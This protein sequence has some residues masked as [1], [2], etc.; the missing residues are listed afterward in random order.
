[1][2]Q[3]ADRATFLGAH[4]LDTVLGVGAVV[5]GKVD[6]PPRQHRIRQN[7]LHRFIEAVVNEPGPQVGIAGDDRLDGIVEAVDVEPTGQGDIDLHRIRIGATLAGTPRVAAMKQQSLLQRG[8]RQNIGDPVGALKVPELL[9]GKA[10]QR[11]IRRGEPAPTVAHMG[12]DAGKGIKPELAEPGHPGGIKFGGRPAPG[13]LQVRAGVGVEGDRVDLHG[14]HQR[15][16]PPS[17]SRIGEQP[18]RT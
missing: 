5:T 8:Q 9:L 11:E 18:A 2:S 4:P 1:M 10:G 17:S 3:I 6:I 12:A 16:R 15:H 7:H 14:V 13:G